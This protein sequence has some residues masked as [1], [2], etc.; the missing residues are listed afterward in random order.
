[1]KKLKLLITTALLAVTM[2]TAAQPKIVAHRGYWTKEGS[3]QNT[4]TALWE[5]AQLGCY[6]SEFD[7]WMT[8][9]GVLVVN[10][11]ATIQDIRIEDTTYAAL[12]EIQLS[13]GE[14]LPTLSEYLLLGKQLPETQLIL[15]IKS[16]RNDERN[17]Q[18]LQKVLRFV[19]RMGLDGQVEYIAFSQYVCRR[20][21]EL[22]PT[23]KVAYLTGDLS[24][25]EA[26]EQLGATGIDYP[27]DAYDRNP[28]WFQQ[29]K[30]CQMEVNVWTVDGEENLRRFATNPCVDIITTNNPDLLK[31]MLC[32]TPA[33]KKKGRK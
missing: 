9:D 25:R 18:C 4:M 3:A 13:N 10:H 29:A 1:M 8:V 27:M 31:T 7:V 33:P 5:A 14:F 12:Q 17:E 26:Q 23:A 11:D 16:H 30:D 22:R 2:N 15:E 24:P 20:L 21:H 19:D 32:P 6:G 28:G